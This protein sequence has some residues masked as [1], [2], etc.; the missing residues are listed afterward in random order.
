MNPLLPILG[1]GAGL[2]LLTSKKTTTTPSTTPP[3]TPPGHGTVTPPSS[4][5]PAYYTVMRGDYPG[6]IAE[7]LTGDGGRWPELIRANPHK[8]VWTRSEISKLKTKP[9]G[10][11]AGNFKTLYAGERL[12]LPESW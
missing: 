2:L 3:G 10:A 9:A 5:K 11:M 6:K 4:S 8:P 12:I 7:K 1:V